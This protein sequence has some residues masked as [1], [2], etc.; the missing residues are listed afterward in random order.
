M[1]TYET[2]FLFGS[3]ENM[4]TFCNI[5]CSMH[6]RGF[7]SLIRRNSSSSGLKQPLPGKGFILPALYF[8]TQFLCKLAL[9][10]SSRYNSELCL[11]SSTIKWTD[12]F[13]N[14]F[15]FFLRF[16]LIRTPRKRTLNIACFVSTFSEK[17]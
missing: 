16:L 14:S 3:T 1:I 6:R 2:I 10:P 17:D 8:L 13:L 15:I 5:T 9:T 4:S 11:P 7:S 12:S